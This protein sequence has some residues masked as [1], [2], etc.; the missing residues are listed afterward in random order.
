MYTY[1]EYIPHASTTSNE[2]SALCERL[3]GRQSAAVLV[4]IIF[5]FNLLY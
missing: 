5:L 4:V 3:R 2:L 1:R